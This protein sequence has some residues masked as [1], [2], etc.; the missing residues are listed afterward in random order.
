[1]GAGTQIADFRLPLQR[2]DLNVHYAAIRQR[3][4]RSDSL[5]QQKWIGSVPSPQGRVTPAAA[6][7]EPP[8]VAAFQR[9]T[10]DLMIVLIIDTNTH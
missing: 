4:S 3:P 6:T 5:K 7:P 8:G 1:M 9:V 10:F 2:Y